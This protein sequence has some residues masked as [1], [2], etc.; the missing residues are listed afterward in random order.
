MAAADDAPAAAARRRAGVGP[1]VRR[2]RVDR[3]RG[4]VPGSV[5]AAPPRA[6]AVCASAN[7]AGMTI[8]TV[9]F[10]LDGV[11]IA[12]EDMWNDVRR[13]LTEAH[14]GRWNVETDQ[15]S[16]MGDNSMQ[17]A[18]RMR[19]RNGVQ[20]S[21]NE[22]YEGIAG[23]LREKYARRLPLISGA[24]EA[25]ASLSLEYRLGLASSSPLE[26]IEYVL[27]LAGLSG[28][29]SAV[30]SS[31]EVSRGKPEPYVYQEAC[32]RL[33]TAPERAAAVEDSAS[34]ILAASSAGLAVIA[35]PNPEFPPS[36]DTLALAD[37]VLSSIVQLDRSVVASLR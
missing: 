11:I 31:D 9:I 22:I 18:A 20:L 13:S 5:R 35:I 16:L 14:G 33:G 24:R 28:D 32:T 27:E 36:A 30:V 21:V 7:L 17:W 25:I 10:D 26:L 4:A 15:Q 23:G 8:D 12:S 19:E 3:P 6:V 29:F 2:G 34:G 1:P 37:M